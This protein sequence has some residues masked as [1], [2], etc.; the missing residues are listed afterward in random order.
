MN[1][2]RLRVSRSAQGPGAGRTPIF[3]RNAVLGS[4]SAKAPRHVGRIW[5]RPRGRSSGCSVDGA[6]RRDDD[7]RLNLVGLALHPLRCRLQR[8]DL[9]RLQALC[10]AQLRDERQPGGTRRCER[11][12]GLLGSSYRSADR[13]A[14]LN[15]RC[16]QARESQ[17]RRFLDDQV[18]LENRRVMELLRS[19]ETTA[20]KLPLVVGAPAGAPPMLG[21]AASPPPQVPGAAPTRATRPSAGWPTT[22][23]PA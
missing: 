2:S 12:R 11:S 13:C 6:F 20:L 22:S 10:P 19:I 8:I 1:P 14:A 21:R 16:A 9:C 4:E 18:W 17:L 15:E 23:S 3:R 7:R 5:F